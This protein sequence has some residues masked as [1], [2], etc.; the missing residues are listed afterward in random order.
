MSCA[1]LCRLSVVVIGFML[2]TSAAS[3]DAQAQARAEVVWKST[4]AAEVGVGQTY[5][6]PLSAEVSGRGGTKVSYK[7]VAGPNGMKIGSGGELTWTPP[8]DALGDYAVRV[9]ASASGVKAT[10]QAFYLTVTK[11]W[12][13]G[14]KPRVLHYK[15][16]TPGA[17]K[18][19]R[20]A[21]LMINTL[22]KPA[23][24]NPK[25]PRL[26]YYTPEKLGHLFFNHEHGSGAYLREASY[27]KVAVEGTVVGWLE[28]PK[29]GLNDSD[30]REGVSGYFNMASDVIKFSDYDIFYVHALVDGE[31]QQAGWLY[32]Q[33]SVQT[34]QGMVSG[35]GLIW[36]INAGVFDAAP[37]ERSNWSSGEAVL[38]TTSWAHEFLHTIG[39]I[40]HANSYNTDEQTLATTG[41]ENP[42]RAYGNPFSIM[43]EHAYA[44]HPD[45]L[46]K[47]R[48][49]WLSEKQLPTVKKSGEYKLYPLAVNDKNTKGLFI[50]ISPAI[51][52]EASDAGFGGFLI[53]YRTPVGFD[54]YLARLDGSEF[55][56]AY[57][58]QGEVDRNGVL[59]YMKYA[60]EDTDGSVLLDMNPKTPYNAKRGIKWQ[61]NAGKF[62]DAILPVGRSFEYEDRLKVTPLGVSDDGAMRVRV[63]LR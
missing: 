28:A 58:P 26:E 37:L 18:V 46:M 55:L 22:S 63:E 29:A 34:R 16:Q 36:M 38:P 48:L 14:D 61:G 49:G 15:S 21:I 45:V 24:D 41:T 27:D 4:P 59:V 51:K 5:V 30:I 2:L 11:P 10:E 42:I 44:T 32:P 52:H 12:Q 6:Y 20:V 3:A 13:A 35:I 17:E 9:Q 57:K 54:R 31:G 62:A 40:G 47:S 23:E 53:E 43:G 19:Y 7:L 50:P 60:S 1:R 39:I 33:Q 56:S 25:T 8:A